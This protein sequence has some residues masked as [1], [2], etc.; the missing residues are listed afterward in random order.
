MTGRIFSEV[1]QDCMPHLGKKLV[2]FCLL[3]LVAW[4]ATKI[5]FYIAFDS[6]GDSDYEKGGLTGQIN[7]HYWIKGYTSAKLH[8]PACN[9]VLVHVAI[10]ST[11]LIMMAMS[12]VKQ[13]WRRK[14]GYYFFSFAILLGTHTLPASWVMPQLPL[15]ILFLCTCALVM[16]NGVLGLRTLANY[17]RDPVKAEKDLAMEYGLITLGSVR[18]ISLTHMPAQVSTQVSSPHAPAYVFRAT[19]RCRLCGIHLHVLQ[20][21]IPRRQWRLS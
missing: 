7:L 3:F 19:V 6:N 2:I 21:Q 4:N 12:L 10:G 15:R 17:D 13:A 11:V 8:S 20:N 14:Y 16:V 18:I 9:F 1:K 5:P